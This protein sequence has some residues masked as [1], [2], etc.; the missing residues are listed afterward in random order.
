MTL[1]PAEHRAAAERELDALRG[2]TAGAPAWLGHAQA[3]I[4][5][6]LT[7]VAAYLEPPP[8]PDIPGLP[9]GWRLD[10]K[11][12]EAGQQMWGWILTLPDGREER[13]DRHR[14]G[15]SAAALTAGLKAADEIRQNSA[16]NGRTVEFTHFPPESGMDD[17]SAQDNGLIG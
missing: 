12:S 5:H 7:A 1:T 2:L 14:W 8:V 13:S 4:A 10:T 9:P 17:Q 11:Q 16:G 15:T 6:V 3:A